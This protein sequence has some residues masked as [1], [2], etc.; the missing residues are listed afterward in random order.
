MYSEHICDLCSITV[1]HPSD[2][3]QSSSRDVNRILI[4]SIQMQVRVEAETLHNLFFNIMKIAFPDSDFQEV[5]DSMSFANPGGGVN[6]S[7]ALSAKHSGP[8]HKQRRSTA[9][10]AEQHGSG[11]GKHSQHTSVGEAPSRVKPERHSGPGSRDPN[12]GT[13]GLLPH[14][15]DLFIVKKKRQERMRGSI[16]SPSSSG[17]GPLS[18]P[19]NPGRMGPSPSPRGARTPFQRDPH[20]SQ[21]GMPGWG[22]HSDRGGSSSPGIGDIHWAKPAK[23][24]RTD[25]G[26]RRPSQM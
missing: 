16:G 1:L 4:C 9:T 24:Q 21:Q 13:A 10:D 15:G 5:K 8:G 6:S 7:A 25:S 19:S 20:P 3:K 22:A 18:P 23:R 14:P 12:L 11:S 2:L 26:K 17:R